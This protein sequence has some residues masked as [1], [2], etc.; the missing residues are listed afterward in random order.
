MVSNVILKTQRNDG[1]GGTEFSSVMKLNEYLRDTLGYPLGLVYAS[2][3]PG[4]DKYMEC[5][6]FIGAFNMLDIPGVIEKLWSI[7]WE[8]PEY[9]QMFVQEHGE[10]LMKE[11]RFVEKQVCE[12]APAVN[13]NKN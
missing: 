2:S 1:G 3:N 6:V 13:V 7:D 5:D 12:N 11:Y 4:G 8:Y 10:T 9:V